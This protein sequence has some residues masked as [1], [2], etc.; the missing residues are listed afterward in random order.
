MHVNMTKW[1]IAQEIGIDVMDQM[2]SF[3]PFV[4]LS[5]LFLDVHLSTSRVTISV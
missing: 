2:A 5:Q 4:I 3:Y 1:I